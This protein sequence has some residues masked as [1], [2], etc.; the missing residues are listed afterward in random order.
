MVSNLKISITHNILNADFNMNIKFEFSF[1]F[2]NVSNA[3]VTDLYS[4]YLNLAFELQE[5]KQ[6]NR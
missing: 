5:F 6:V 3:N 2:S 4:L 1:K